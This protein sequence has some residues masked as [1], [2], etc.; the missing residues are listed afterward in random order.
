[1]HS[2][3]V[4]IGSGSDPCRGRG[5]PWAPGATLVED[6]APRSG[7]TGAW[8]P[9]A[10]A[11]GSH[12][13]L[14]RPSW[15]SE[16]ALSSGAAR[17]ED[18]GRPWVPG[19]ILVENGGGLG[20]RERALGHGSDPCRG[21]GLDLGRTGPGLREAW[22]PGAVPVEGGAGPEVRER[23]VSRTGGGPGCWERPLSRTGPAQASGS[24]PCRGSGPWIWR[25]P[26]GSDRGVAWI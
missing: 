12:G 11:D 14:E 10:L 2:A 21:S 8:A 16:P 26:P 15:R 7:A 4:S 20:F 13:L 23:P 9:E 17:G 24:D 5:R 22:A 6:R 3:G 1:M 18:G 19:A 25:P